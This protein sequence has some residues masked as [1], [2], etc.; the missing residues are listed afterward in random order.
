MYPV[1]VLGLSRPSK[2]VE[3]IQ[4]AEARNRVSQW[5]P[6]ARAAYTGVQLAPRQSL[7]PRFLL[8]K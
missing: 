4:Q 8:D 5:Y 6:Q 7:K 2:A 3:L 1:I